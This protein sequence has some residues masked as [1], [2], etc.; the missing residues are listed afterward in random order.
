[1]YRVDHV[2]TSAKVEQSQTC[3]STV[4]GNHARVVAV[5]VVQEGQP[6]IV[7]LEHSFQGFIRYSVQPRDD[8]SDIVRVDIYSP[9]TWSVNFTSFNV[10]YCGQIGAVLTSMDN[11]VA[12]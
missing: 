1:M 10:L 4:R 8:D 2:R 3:T 7:A 9:V 6:I 5:D 12:M 11:P